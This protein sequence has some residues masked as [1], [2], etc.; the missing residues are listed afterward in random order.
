MTKLNLTKAALLAATAFFATAAQAQVADTWDIAGDVN[1]SAINT[2]KVTNDATGGTAVQSIDG[3]NIADGYKNSISAAAVGASAS[4]SFNVLDLSQTA[5]AGTAVLTL[6][7]G[8]TVTGSNTGAVTN[9]S[10]L[11]TANVITAGSGNSISVAGV[12]SSA[13]G[14]VSVTSGNTTDIADVEYSTG[15]AVLI[16]SGNGTDP[17]TSTNLSDAG[18]NLGDVTVSL[19]TGIFGGDIAGGSANSISVAGVGSSAS[20]GVSVNTVDNSPIENVAVNLGDSLTVTASN[21]QATGGTGVS[22][23]GTAIDTAQIEGG[24]ANSISVAAVGASASVSVANTFYQ[25]TDVGSSVGALD[26]EFNDINVSSLNS[27]NVANTTDIS[28]SATIGGGQNNSF[29]IAGVGA[30]ASTSFSVTDYSAAGISAGTINVGGGVTLASNNTGNV[31]VT[32]GI[33]VPT[34]SAGYNNSISTA[35]VGASASQ[36]V[37]H[38]SLPAQ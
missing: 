37:S 18:G 9:T 24:N 27:A 34:I 21:G 15:G 12:G 5:N 7:G 29:S 2:G 8:V 13:S 26:V 11:T 32:A 36:A 20:F 25:G 3:A 17:L 22:V 10:D 30:S 19:A 38:I 28:T 31:S 6:E 1:V 16:Q 23:T 35:A 33:A 14:S 4:S